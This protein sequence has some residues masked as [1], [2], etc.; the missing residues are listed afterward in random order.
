MNKLLFSTSPI[1][2]HAS[3]AVL[4]IGS[5]LMILTHGWSKI[6][7]FT[8]TLSTFRDPI[9][10][11]SAVSL[12]L[13]IFAEFFCAI[14]L[15]LGFLTRLSLIPLIFTMA[16]AAFIVHADDPFSTKEKALLFLLV[17]IFQF[18]AG[19]GRYSVDHQIKNKRRY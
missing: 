15:G 6:S 9:G 2:L 14:L 8:S 4:R 12:Q 18:F 17:F 10:L 3:L 19:P 11:G 1:F 13:A 16:V 7:N 5:A